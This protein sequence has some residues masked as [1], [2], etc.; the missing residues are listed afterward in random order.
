TPFPHGSLLILREQGFGDF[1][2]ASRF[3]PAAKKLGGRVVV[4]CRRELIPLF[5]HVEGIGE[6]FEEPHPRPPSME[7]PKTEFIC[8]LM[9]LPGL[10]NASFERM[11]P[12]LALSV[13]AD[14]RARVAPLLERC[15]RRLKVGI[16]WSGSVTFRGNAKRSVRLERFLDLANAPGVQLISLQKGPR[17]SE[18]EESGAS[19]AVLDAAPYLDDF[20]DTAALVQ[21]LDLVIMTDSAVAHLA[22]TLGVPVW[23]LLPFLPYWLYGP[24]GDETPWYPSMRLFRQPSP[25]DWDSVFAEVRRN[26]HTLAR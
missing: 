25:G 15:G 12:P 10:F 1:L 9:D 17:R 22:G 21:G 3:L 19:P 24:E 26:L 14:A 5:K 16:V 23:N 8:P 13:P 4:T 6:L 20:A 11:T 2:F 18:L 7:V